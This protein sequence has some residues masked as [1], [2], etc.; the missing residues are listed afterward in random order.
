[1]VRVVDSGP[2]VPDDEVFPELGEELILRVGVEVPY[3]PVVVKNLELALG[4]ADSHEEV[5]FLISGMVRIGCPLLGSDPC[6][7]GGA[8]V[9][10]GYIESVD[11]S[12]EKTRDPGDGLVVIDYPEP[13]A[14]AVLVREIIFRGLG[15]CTCHYLAESLVVLVGEEH[16]F[17]VGVLYPHMDHPVVFLVLAG[18]FVLLD[19][20]RGIVVS[21]GAQDQSVLRP[22]FH[23]LG[24]DVVAFLGV[25][26]QPS[27][28]LPL[29]EVLDRPVIDPLVVFL[30][31]GLEIDLGLG[32]VEE[33]LLPGHLPGFRGVQDVVRGSRNFG[34]NAL[35]RPYCREWF[36]SYHDSLYF[37]LTWKRVFPV[38]K[39]STIWRAAASPAFMLASAVWA[40]IFLGVAKTRS[41]NFSLRSS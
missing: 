23:G 28:L 31:H 3:D 13:V 20:P 15:G 30:E 29:L 4:E 16:G 39:K 36:D 18:Q 37:A 26:P 6:G 19:L 17:D 33:G 9:A 40:P 14:E 38:A 10:V 41:P 11:F 22:P 35:W 24:V 7:G 21:V 5:V 12:G 1:M 8:V 2:H 27:F 25:A 32:Y 34:D